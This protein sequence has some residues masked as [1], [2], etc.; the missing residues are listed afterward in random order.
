MKLA[1]MQPYFFPY[2]GYFQLINAVDKFIF[3]DDVNFIKQGWINRNKILLN[4]K[5]F[6]FSI[7]IKNISPNKKINETEIASKQYEKWMEKFLRTIY[8]AYNKAPSFDIVNS[9]IEKTIEDN[10]E[11]ISKLTIE[12]IKNV[13][14]YLNIETTFE[15]SSESYSDSLGFEKAERLIDICKKNNAD[16]YINPIGGMEIYTKEV[17]EKKNVKL[18]FL[19]T[20]N[21]KYDQYGGEFISNLSIIDIMMF[22][23]KDRIIEML[24]KYK[25]T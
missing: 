14:N 8:S 9:M 22:N 5:E 3:Y 19:S 15:L 23:S 18:S 2:L 11:Y 17:F 21:I 16:H 1:I 7:P 4:N 20:N 13:C 25:L 10:F 6:L 12:S 24:N